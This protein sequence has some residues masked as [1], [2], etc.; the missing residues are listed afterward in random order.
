MHPAHYAVSYRASFK[1]ELPAFFI[2]KLL[3]RKG[4][5]VLDPFGGRGTTAFQANL[6]G[7]RAIHNDINP[8]A[9]FL[10]RARQ[11]IPPVQ[12]LV[13]RVKALDLSGEVDPA[14]GEVDRLLPFFHPETLREILALREILR[15]SRFEDPELNYI[16]LTALSRL[17][18]HSDGFFSV[19]T[20][21]QISILPE[22]QRLNNQRKG[23]APE[24]KNVK[25]RII[26]K[27][28]R[29]V[30]RTLPDVY[31]QSSAQNAYLDC[32]ARRISY[33]D[34]SIDL[35]VT[36]PPFLDKVDYVQDNW[37]RAWFLDV[38]ADLAL[39]DLAI[40][41]H[42]KD[43]LSFMKEVMLEMLRL[44]RPGGQAI[45]EVGEVEYRKRPL[46]LEELLLSLLP[47]ETDH[48]RLLGREVWI[49]EQNF[50]KL[51]NCW[52]VENNTRGTNTNRCLVLQKS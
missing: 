42:P 26:R 52:K 48:G 43:W 12:T 38:E 35:I 28:E 44:L 36:S 51:A 8:V 1:P 4:R 19:Y 16:G 21:P 49:N 3:K 32:D 17:Y 37:M 22:R 9:V 18:G 30:G 40:L 46:N 45:I 47:L 10:G 23:V 50:T 13:K 15:N 31:H 24:Y 5:T 7:H 34:A 33:P 20:F 41:E 6:M 27:L 25:D 14:S 29:D 11:I 2:G 39:R